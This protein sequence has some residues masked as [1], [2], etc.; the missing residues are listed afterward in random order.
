MTTILA[1]GFLLGMRHALEADHLAAV[2]SLASRC[3][4]SRQATVLGMVWGLGHTI[5][6]FV[7]CSAALFLDAVVPESMARMLEA[8]V[9]VMLLL[10]GFDLFRR[11]IRERVHFHTHRHHDGTVHFH[12]HAH[13]GS[14]EPHDAANAHDHEHLYEPT[15]PARALYVGLV[16]G[17]AG[18]AALILLALGEVTSPWLGMVYVGL[19]GIGSVIGMGVLTAI[20][21]LPLRGARRINSLYNGLQTV[22]GVTTIAVGVALIY[23]TAIQPGS[24]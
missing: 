18:S 2:A 6:L 7:A 13:A 10:L 12:A 4:S 21:S 20:I 9:G 16:H 23:Q 19:F 17:L 3:R 11:M 14:S 15:F 22:L 8:A 1:L 24:L 5:T